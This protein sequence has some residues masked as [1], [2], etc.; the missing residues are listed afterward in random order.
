MNESGEMTMNFSEET[1]TQTAEPVAIDVENTTQSVDLITT[2]DEGKDPEDKV[3][4]DA[5]TPQADPL[6]NSPADKPETE[7]EASSETADP[8]E[9][10]TQKAEE[11]FKKLFEKMSE[12]D[13]EILMKYLSSSEDG[14]NELEDQK[15]V[16]FIDSLADLKRLLVILIALFAM[17]IFKDFIGSDKEPEEKEED[18]TGEE[19][20][21]F[22]KNL[23]LPGEPP[24]GEENEELAKRIYGEE[25]GD[26]K[27]SWENF[28]KEVD[29]IKTPSFGELMCK[30]LSANDRNSVKGI[31]IK[32]EETGNSVE[33][34]TKKLLRNFAKKQLANMKKEAAAQNRAKLALAA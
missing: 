32:P 30:V 17:L 16:K 21:F 23:S 19:N 26:S 33:S 13:R 2:S 8:I 5:D 34:N 27:K 3:S 4:K 28:R 9:E 1:Q 6:E 11:E 20:E 18:Q 15:D 7:K 14:D 25:R 31:K 10:E 12:R 24:E 22:G 29:D